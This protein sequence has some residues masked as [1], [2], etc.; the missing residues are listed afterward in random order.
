MCEL[1]RNDP[2]FLF[3]CSKCGELKPNKEFP[4]RRGERRIREYSSKCK[5]CTEEIRKVWLQSA[6]GKERRKIIG[7]RY[8]CNNSDYIK[9]RHVDYKK[10]KPL[11]ILFLTCRNNAKKRSIEFNIDKAF[12]ESL[13]GKQEG[14]C[15]Y[16]G[17]S[18]TKELSNENSWSID[19]INSSKHYT[20]D[21]VV[22][23]CYRVNVCKNNLTLEEFIS[24]SQKV[25]NKFKS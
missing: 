8:A 24:M 21:N 12:I 4:V 7:K 14:K 23:C 6:N 3:K 17:D 19:R 18:M 1:H 13:W 9:Y 5:S 16:T 22:L 20:E 11:N 2:D 15:F 25:I 10:R